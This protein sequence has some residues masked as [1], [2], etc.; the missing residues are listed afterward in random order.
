MKNKIFVPLLL[1]ASSLLMAQNHTTL[2]LEDAINRSLSNSKAVKV[3]EAATTSAEWKAKTAKNH[4][5]PDLNISG[6]YQ[7]ILSKG[8]TKLKMQLP[9]GAGSGMVNVNPDHVL[10]GTAGVSLPIYAGGQIKGAIKQSNLAVDLSKLQLESTKEDV[11]WQTINLYFGIYKT[12][13]TLE[14]L[15]EN[16]VR[17]NQRVKDFQNFL[18]NGIIARND[19]LRAKLQAS[20]VQIA[21]EEATNNY[22]NLNYRLKVLMGDPN[23]LDYDV[24]ESE[25]IVIENQSDESLLQRKDILSVEKQK[26]IAEEAIRIAKAAYYPQ[27]GFTGNYY[28]I[29]IDQI[30]SM[31]NSLTVGVGLKYDLSSIYKNKR[32]VEYARAKK[33]ETEMQL[34]AL[35]DK[36]KIELN[37]AHQ[38]YTLAE[39]KNKV[40]EEAFEQAVENYRIVKDKYDNGLADTDQLLEADIQQLQAEINKVVGEA[41]QALAGYEFLYTQGSLIESTKK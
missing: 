2:R 5:L 26:E 9:A 23:D 10:F 20:N 18:D 31:F 12:Q 15:N 22:V 21:I 19:F 1:V 13:K 25:N 3:S 33:V 7:Q 36:A 4:Q 16:L 11:V 30:A 17:A 35:K 41:D 32:E 39:K 28:A 40:Y 34:E 29:D 38:K 37:E 8:D 27:I 6:Q 24:M 14:V